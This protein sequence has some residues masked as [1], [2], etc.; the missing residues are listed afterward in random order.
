M[1]MGNWEYNACLNYSDG[2]YGYIEGYKK[3]A[4]VLVEYVFVSKRDQ[5]TLIYPIVFL[6]RHHVELI[7]KDILNKGKDLL[8]LDEKERS[9]LVSA[10]VSKHS[11]TFFDK[12]VKDLMF[13]LEPNSNHDYQ[14]IHSLIEKI[15]QLDPDSYHFRYLKSKKDEVNINLNIRTINTED[16]FSNIENGIKLLECVSLQLSQYLEAIDEYIKG[17]RSC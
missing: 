15:T 2:S 10:L 9:V 13:A 8:S 1:V 7:I 5:D 17:V 4:K 16:L 3:A 12:Y 14:E 11:L 6:F